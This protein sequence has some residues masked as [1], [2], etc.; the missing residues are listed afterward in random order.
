MTVSENI[1]M[2]SPVLALLRKRNREETLSRKFVEAFRIKCT[3]VKHV[4]QNLSGGNQQKAV[5][6]RWVARDPKVLILDEPTRGIDVQAKAEVHALIGQMVS[7][8]MAVILIS[9]EIDEI[10]GLCDRAVVLFEG[11]V[12][13]EIERGDFSEERILAYSHGHGPMTATR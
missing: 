5:I 4:V 8:G 3:S 1:C 12:V 9:S 11:Q 6:S 2:G 10:I 13:G 7:K